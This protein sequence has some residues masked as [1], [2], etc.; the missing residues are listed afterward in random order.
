MPYIGGQFDVTRQAV[1]S[2]IRL[3]VVYLVIALPTNVVAQL[4]STG[5]DASG[6]LRLPPT[7]EA[8]PTQPEELPPQSLTLADVEQLALT[9]NPTLTA[10]RAQIVAA[11]GRQVQAG[12]YPNTV[13]GYMSDEM[14]DD[15]T[16]GMQGG[17]VGQRFVTG[18][19]LRLDRAMAARNVQEMQ[20]TRNSQELRVL[21][22]VRLRFYDALVAQRKVEL[23][24]KLLSISQ[25]FTDLSQ[26]LLD[27]LQISQN[28]LLLV[29]IETEES[30]IAAENAL[31]EQ[32]EAWHRL[33]AVIGVA[34]L[35]PLPLSGELAS[36]LPVYDWDQS[37]AEIL[38]SSPELAA[39]AARVERSRLATERARRENIPNIDL[40][41]SV[42]RMNQDGDNIAGVQAGFPLPVLNRN[43]GNIMKADAELV[44]A[45]NDVR[46]IELDLRDRLAIAFRRYANA[47]QQ[48]DRY[49]D[50]ILPRAQRSLD[51]VTR[52]YSAGQVDFLTLLTSQRT[53]IR[54]NLSYLASLA[55]LRRAAIV[56]Q[57]QLLTGSLKSD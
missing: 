13:I 25:N 53:Y 8:L 15:G 12:L 44:A 40:M 28:D 33:T 43:Q 6:V 31:N 57:G 20:S 17:F 46:R 11:R 37:Y 9:N 34:S 4:P 18:G 1:G 36:D 52:G 26:Q 14:G 42:Q 51:I 47:K 27:A 54:T 16:A 5:N 41:V 39:A 49:T 21:N 24:G 3:V 38:G 30:Q 48:V 45:S 29:E 50:S 7:I 55:E 35:E 32:K 19:K 56:I 23:T 2:G 22:D 10:A